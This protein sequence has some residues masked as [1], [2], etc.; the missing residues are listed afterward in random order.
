M[1]EHSKHC[2]SFGNVFR[3]VAVFTGQDTYT[4]ALSID[5]LTSGKIDKDWPFIN[6]PLVNFTCCGKWKEE[7]IG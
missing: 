6:T 1:Y 5:D 3:L 4:Q 2:W 7:V